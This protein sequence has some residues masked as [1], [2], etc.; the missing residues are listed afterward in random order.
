M[1]TWIVCEWWDVS[2]DADGERNRHVPGIY[3]LR[4]PVLWAIS[5]VGL[6]HLVYTERVGGSNPSSPTK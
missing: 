4:I 5:V 1:Y 2:Q 3:R 6:A